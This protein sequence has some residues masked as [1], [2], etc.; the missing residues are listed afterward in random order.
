M[1]VMLRQIFFTILVVVSSNCKKH[2]EAGP[3]LRELLQKSIIAPSWKFQ[4]VNHKWNWRQKYNDKAFEA[5]SIFVKEFEK[6]YAAT[7]NELVR[8][9]GEESLIESR[10]RPLESISQEL[11]DDANKTIND[12]Y[13]VVT[14]RVTFPTVHQVSDTT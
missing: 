7:K 12:L 5:I 13:D 3:T 1:S 14:W 8:M 10:L 11:D 9:F 6:S 2:Q 4:S